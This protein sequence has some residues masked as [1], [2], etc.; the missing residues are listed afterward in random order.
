LKILILFCTIIIF[1]C[2]KE[3][4]IGIKNH[5]YYINDE[6]DRIYAYYLYDFVSKESLKSFSE[7]VEHE[8]GR[9]TI[10]YYFSHNANIPFRE[11]NKSLTFLEARLLMQKYFYNI[12]YVYMRDKNTRGRLVDCME[13]PDDPLCNGS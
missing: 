6:Y 2:G 5:G 11:L 8:I 1:S 13:I 7:T 9:T 10:Q 3:N 12:K 4:T